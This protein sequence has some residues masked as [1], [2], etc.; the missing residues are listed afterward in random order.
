LEKL[1]SLLGNTQK[2]LIETRE[3]LGEKFTNE[4]IR[5]K[6]AISK[7]SQLELDL[8]KER[9]KNDKERDMREIVEKELKGI[10]LLFYFE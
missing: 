5:S 7:N 1:K 4:K 3:E 10:C 2:E 6:E 9:K 8:D